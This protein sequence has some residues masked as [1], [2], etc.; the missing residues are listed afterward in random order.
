MPIWTDLPDTMITIHPPIVLTGSGTFTVTVQDEHGISMEGALVCCYIPTQEPVMHSTA[1]TNAAGTAVLDVSPETDGDTMYVTATKHNYFAK[2]SHALVH[3]SG[4]YVTS[5]TL[6][7]DDGHDGQVNMGESVDLGVWARNWGNEAA[8]RVSGVLSESDPYVT[9]SSSDSRYGRIRANDSALSRTPYHFSVANDC[10]NQHIVRFDLEFRDGNNNTWI[11]HPKLTVFAP[12]LRLHDVAVVDDDNGD[13]V[14][15][16]GENADLVVTLKNDGDATAVSTIGLLTSSSEYVTITTP[17]SGFGDIEPG[18]AGDNA[19]DP[20]TVVLDPATPYGTEIE[21]SVFVQ[22]GAYSE[23]L[24]F[25]LVV[26]APVLSLMEVNVVND[27]NGNGLLEPGEAADL[28]A[29]FTNEGEATANKVTSVLRTESPYSA[30]YDS[31][32]AF[33]SIASGDT[34]DNTDDPYTVFADSATPNFEEIP[35]SIVIQAGTFTDTF[36]FTVTVYVPLITLQDVRV[37]N[38][39]DGDNALE[40]GETGD[41][42]VTLH[43]EGEVGAE[44]LSSVLSSISSHITFVD[45]LAYFGTIDPGASVDNAADPYTV[46]ADNETPYFSQVDFSIA[47]EAGLYEDTL[48]FALNVGQCPP[49][50]TGYYWAFYS[51]GPHIQS[52]VFE[53]V[54]IDTMT[55]TQYPGTDLG[56]IN[57]Q[58]VQVALPFTFSYYG[59]DYD[60]ISISSNGWITPGST[61]STDRSNSAI[62]HLDGPKRMI[63]GVWDDLNPDVHWQ[64]EPQGVFYYYD[65]TNH[66]FIVEYYQISHYPYRG[67][68]YETFEVILHDPAYYPTPT[69]DGEI[70]VQYLTRMHQNIADSIWGPDC[71]AWDNT[72][73]IENQTETVGVQYYYDGVYHRLADTITDSFAIKYTTHPKGAYPRYSRDMNSTSGGTMQVRSHPTE[74]FPTR[75]LLSTIQPNPFARHTKIQYQLVNAST[76]NLRVYDAAGRLVNRLVEAMCQPGYYTMV[77]DGCDDVGRRVPAGIYF[78][79]FETA[80]YQK[81]EKAVLLR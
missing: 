17:L 19:G 26:L 4:P 40:P 56:L 60:V 21:F 72:V 81:V 35:F 34:A 44:D 43:N 52:P 15:G 27:D 57:E 55:Q 71:D 58:T 3:E 50:D 53:W 14:L 30:I 36:D 28:V 11:S 23:T 9:I 49:S 12:V 24:D 47:V 64:P 7:I 69:G 29:T 32:G 31:T 41:L 48:G 33:G 61:N 38:D 20:F 16:P 10:P 1:Y 70:I 18:M 39:T 75:T 46:I 13:G 80:D 68:Q 37:V 2:E 51:S 66:R 54:A 73:G 62:P 42:V 59:A 25:S 67:N 5:S 76:V 45:S 65:E 8:G 74:S 22:A 79:R 77:W 78:V 6:I 63:A